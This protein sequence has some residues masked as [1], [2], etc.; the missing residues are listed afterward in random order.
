MVLAWNLVASVHSGFSVTHPASTQ[1]L[2]SAAPSVPQRRLLTNKLGNNTDFTNDLFHR[3]GEEWGLH[4]PPPQPQQTTNLCK[5][6]RPPNPCL[7]ALFWEF[8]SLLFLN[9]C[10]GRLHLCTISLC[11]FLFP[12][13][14]FISF[15]FLTV[16]IQY[17]PTRYLQA[18]NSKSILMLSPI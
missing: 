6:T 11:A 18:C 9:A 1:M 15:Y 3:K 17:C 7:T 2:N 8:L 16:L 4:T 5:H 14:Q 13:I 10:P 12:P